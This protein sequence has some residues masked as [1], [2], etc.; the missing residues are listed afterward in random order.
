[1]LLLLQFDNSMLPK[2]HLQL[3]ISSFWVICSLPYR[4]FWNLR[5]PY[6]MYYFCLYR[7]SMGLLWAHMSG[8]CLEYPI[9]KTTNCWH[10]VDA[11]FHAGVMYMSCTV[12][13]DKA[14]IPLYVNHFHK[15]TQGLAKME[16]Q[17]SFTPDWCWFSRWGRERVAIVL[18]PK[19]SQYVIY[20]CLKPI[21][22]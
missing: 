12:S 17:I 7:R 2:S 8:Q 5:V 22:S 15:A 18:T 16:N 9:H 20:G 6:Y 11:Q 1:M 14:A 4:L 13:I 10:S 21:T 3:P 19:A